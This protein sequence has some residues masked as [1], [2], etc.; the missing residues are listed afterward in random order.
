MDLELDHEQNIVVYGNKGKIILEIP[1]SDEY[2]YS[3]YREEL[4][5]KIVIEKDELECVLGEDIRSEIVKLKFS[6]P[7][8]PHL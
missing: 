8:S 3:I 2:I 4:E 5:E 7:D 1:K 6:S